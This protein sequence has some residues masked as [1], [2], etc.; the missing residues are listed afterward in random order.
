MYKFYNQHK[1]HQQVKK[2]LKYN[3]KRN[4]K[5]LYLNNINYK[6]VLALG[7]KIKRIQVNN[8][9]TEI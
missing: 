7:I 3:K 1:L 8:F 2:I 4:N 6:K 5:K 9:I